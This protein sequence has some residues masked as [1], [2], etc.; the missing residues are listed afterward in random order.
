MRLL[1]GM[2]G[3]AALLLSSSA[4]AAGGPA[5]IWVDVRPWTCASELGPFGRHVQLACDAIG[6][7]CEVASSEKQADFRAS[8]ACGEPDRWALVLQKSDGAEVLSLGLEGDREQR[9]RKAAVWVAHASVGEPP[10]RRAKRS[11]APPEPP[12]EPPPAELPPA[13][14]P[15]VKPKAPVV[16]PVPPPPEVEIVVPP[17][18]SEPTPAVGRVEEA[19]RGG[20]AVSG[21]GGMTS[22]HSVIAGARA[23]AAFPLGAGFAL[24]PAFNYARSMGHDGG[25]NLFL[26]GAMLGWGAP[27]GGRWLG[28]SIEGGGGASVG[29]SGRDHRGG[30]G[31]R[32]AFY[33]RA[34]GTLQ[35]PV[36][37][38]VR[39]FVSVAGTHVSNQ[40]GQ[41]AQTALFEAGFAWRTF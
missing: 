30:G 35:F 24:A 4:F 7:A 15:P 2:G 19:P 29:E 27:F 8:L 20:I 32:H 6:G 22:R 21:V 17:A 28:A 11:A 1:I 31:A 38:A 5:K 36:D 25:G 23:Y 33:G 13:E 37:F 18:G 14:P 26:G 34:A 10:P 12:E 39:P 3:A 16:I 9:L 40:F 41:P